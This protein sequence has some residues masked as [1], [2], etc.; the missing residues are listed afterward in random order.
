MA[1]NISV[2]SLY[3]CGQRPQ[4]TLSLPN[5]LPDTWRV[6]YH[7]PCGA[8]LEAPRRREGAAFGVGE[9]SAEILRLLSLQPK[10]LPRSQR[11]FPAPPSTPRAYVFGL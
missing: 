6:Q 11:V 7:R 1:I 3:L 5:G 2:D 10:H 9:P 8:Q 4:F